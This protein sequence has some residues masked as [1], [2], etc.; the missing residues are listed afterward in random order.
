[1]ARK[2]EYEATLNELFG[3]NIKWSKLAKRELE[4]LVKA[5]TERSTEI[6][7][8]LGA[9]NPKNLARVIDSIIPEEYQG[10]FIRA[11]KKLLMAGEILGGE[12]S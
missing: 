1:M 9:S 6:C 3:T 5:L 7:M 2:E 11:F 8:K 4:E 12:K 10:P